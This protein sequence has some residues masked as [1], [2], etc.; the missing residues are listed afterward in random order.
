MRHARLFRLLLLCTLCLALTACGRAEKKAQALFDQAAL[1]EKGGDLVDAAARYQQLLAEFPKTK[2][3]EQALLAL[4]KVQQRQESMRKQAAYQ[5]IDSIVKVIDG[6]KSMYNRFPGRVRDFDKGDFFFD[7]EYM[8]GTV[9]VGSSVYLA[10][11]GSGAYRLWT[12][13]G[14]EPEG[15]VLD[16]KGGVFEKATRAQ[17]LAELSAQYIEEKKSGGLVFLR[18]ASRQA[19]ATSTTGGQGR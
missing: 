12:F 6:Y 4:Q 15:Y 13:K 1:A 14:E 5:S 16:G 11:G 8:A 2:V 3:A 7:S 9:P 18:P 10:L 17:A 19:A